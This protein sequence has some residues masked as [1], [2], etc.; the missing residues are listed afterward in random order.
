MA[1]NY[2]E[3]KMEDYRKAPMRRATSSGKSGRGC[4][5]EKTTQM[6]VVYAGKLDY[7]GRMVVSRMCASG[8]KV[9]FTS[10]DLNAG[11]EFAQLSGALFVPGADISAVKELM[12]SRWGSVDA[13]VL[14]D[15]TMSFDTLSLNLSELRRVI[16]VNCKSDESLCERCVNLQAPAGLESQAASWCSFLLT[17]PGLC[18][19]TNQVTLTI[20]N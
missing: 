4:F 17:T 13:A 1:D 10:D 20:S 7:L 18:F 3:K 6:H 11:R 19:S 2:L 14:I 8:F 5:T 12:L 16:A 15:C 9:A